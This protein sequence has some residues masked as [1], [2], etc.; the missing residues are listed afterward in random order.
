MITK[1]ELIASLR[2]ET[3]IIKHLA[4]RIPTGTYDWRPT[5][6]Q[7]SMLELLRYLTTCGEIGAR[8]LVTGNWD[9]VAAVEARAAEVSPETFAAAMD[10][11]MQRLEE[12]LADIDPVAASTTERSLPWGAPIKQGQGFV[13]MVVKPMAAYRMQLFLYAK[14][15]GNH[16][17]NSANCWVGV[18]WKG[19]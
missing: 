6:G 4:E 12:L 9:H 18:D 19:A 13:D 15:A 10:G 17:L 8:N 3:K 2:H 1:D 5:P 11:Q 14:Q 16:E 7:R